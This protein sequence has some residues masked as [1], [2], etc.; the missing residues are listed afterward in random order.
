M[1]GEFVQSDVAVRSELLCAEAADRVLEFIEHQRE[2][3]THLVVVIQA[4]DGA[5][6]TIAAREALCEALTALYK[7]SGW[8][9]QLYQNAST[10]SLPCGFA[11]SDPRLGSPKAV[12]AFA[13]LVS[14]CIRRIVAK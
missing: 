14:A 2:L 12:D 4:V 7:P 10:F 11:F 3:S 1:Y 8:A 9:C 6:S 13:A 5:L